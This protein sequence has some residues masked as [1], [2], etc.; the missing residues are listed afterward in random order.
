MITTLP[1]SECI[2]AGQDKHVAAI[3]GDRYAPAGHGTSQDT[4]DVLPAGE[5]CPSEHDQ[6]V[7]LAVAPVASE[8]VPMGHLE[9]RIAPVCAYVPATH[10]VQGKEPELALNLPAVQLAHGPPLAPVKPSLQM[11]SVT[12]LLAEGETVLEGQLLHVVAPVPVKNFPATHSVHGSEPAE[13][14]YLPAVQLTH[15]PPLAP[16]K[17]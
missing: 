15:G 9:H 10:S 2:F 1:I 14:L 13:A 5:V 3:V 11:Q 12:T 17:P 6:Q 16:V 7:T 8:Y 4:L